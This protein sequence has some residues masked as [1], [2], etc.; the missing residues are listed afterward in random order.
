MLNKHFTYNKPNYLFISSKNTDIY[1]I[2][3]Q[4]QKLEFECF[5]FVYMQTQ[6][7]HYTNAGST[8]PYSVLIQSSLDTGNRI[9]P[10]FLL[11][12][13]DKTTIGQKHSY[14][15][16]R[17][18]IHIDERRQVSTLQH[19][20]LSFPE[21]D[22]ALF[23]GDMSRTPCG[24]KQREPLVRVKL[25]NLFIQSLKHSLI[26]QTFCFKFHTTGYVLTRCQGKK[27]QLDSILYKK[28]TF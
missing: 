1:F 28:I 4:F 12:L 9:T 26:E 19:Q 5:P 21:M 14:L 23:Q 17:E 3:S 7:G 11:A 15:N 10:H 13:K 8:Y 6:S 27:L 25:N 18:I 16:L 20:F 2:Y 24:K 22:T